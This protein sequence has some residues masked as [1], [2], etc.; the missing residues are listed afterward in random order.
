MVDIQ[1]VVGAQC[2]SWFSHIVK[3]V[4]VVEIVEVVQA[5]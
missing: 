3:I 1:D 4:Q 5:V 2:R